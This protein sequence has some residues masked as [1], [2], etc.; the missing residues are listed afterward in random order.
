METTRK[1]D[2][3][4]DGLG[5]KIAHLMPTNVCGDLR[6]GKARARFE[7]AVPF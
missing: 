4:R 7:A 2:G 1:L 3:K 6:I 5:R